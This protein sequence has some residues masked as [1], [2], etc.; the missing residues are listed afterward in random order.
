MKTLLDKFFFGLFF[1]IG[2]I[3]LAKFFGWLLIS[4]VMMYMGYL[5]MCYNLDKSLHHICDT[6]A[7]V[8]FAFPYT[9]LLLVAGVLCLLVA[10]TCYKRG[11]K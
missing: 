5:A 8:Q 3:L 11:A 9:A 2:L 6:M 7:T 10:W 1:G 4:I